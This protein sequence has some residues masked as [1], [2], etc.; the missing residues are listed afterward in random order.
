MRNEILV[1]VAVITYNQESFIKQT[2][3]GI[4]FQKCN[5]EF[6]IVIG[7]DCSTD[8]TATI[9]K[10]YAKTYPE[11]IKILEREKNLGFIANYNDTLSKCSGKYIAQCAG[12]DYWTDP[13]KLQKQVDFLE[14]NPAYGLCFHNI[15]QIFEGEKTEMGLIEEFRA[16]DYD[17]KN[18]WE[19]WVIQAATIMFRSK[20]IQD[21]YYLNYCN[22]NSMFHEDVFLLLNATVHGKIFGIDE[23][24]SVYR[25][26]EKSMTSDGSSPKTVNMNKMLDYVTLIG[27]LFNKKYNTISKRYYSFKAFRYSYVCKERRLYFK[28]AGFFIKSFV[29]SPSRFYSLLCKELNTKFKKKT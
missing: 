7:E 20:I 18:I 16:G 3:D 26:H 13:F 28:S 2:L 8:S 10:E 4:I 21:Q 12:D 15:T 1:S 22:H 19:D 27:S 9:C 6:E 5:F 14:N 24:M 17:V 25:K 23:K 11:K 29:S